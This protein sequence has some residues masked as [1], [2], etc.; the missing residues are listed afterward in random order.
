VV[1]GASSVGRLWP[2]P[3][4][5]SVGRNLHSAAPINN[6]KGLQKACRVA[7]SHGPALPQVGRGHRNHA[8]QIELDGA[9][10]DLRD[11]VA[12]ESSV[13][14]P[15]ATPEATY[16]HESIPA[17]AAAYLFTSAQTTRLSMGTTG[18][19]RTLRFTFLLMNDWDI[20][21]TEEELV[22]LVFGNRI[23]GRQRARF[24]TRFAERCRPSTNERGCRV[25]GRYSRTATYSQTVNQYRHAVVARDAAS[26]CRGVRD[27]RH[28][29]PP[30]QCEVCHRAVDPIPSHS[31]PKRPPLRCG[32]T[33][34]SDPRPQR[35]STPRERRGYVRRQFTLP[36]SVCSGG[37]FP[38]HERLA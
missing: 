36:A 4:A 25:A 32:L 28:G 8:E 24:Y 20:G 22:D 18:P 30:D 34:R 23:R 31:V 27:P 2:R 13:A 9:S 19:V 5:P 3:C 38:L 29:P 15:A 14:T 21:I 17:V 33:W 7:V 37:W 10:E 1:A 6:S 12:L 11:P 26:T 35:R 16:L